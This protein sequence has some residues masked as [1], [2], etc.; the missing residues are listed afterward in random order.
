MA[1][2]LDPSCALKI[3]VK[4]CC[5]L[6]SS[7]GAAEGPARHL[8]LI[9]HSF[10]L[11]PFLFG[12][13]TAQTTP[14]LFSYTMEHLEGSEAYVLGAVGAATLIVL[15]LLLRSNPE[16][17]VPYN[18]TPPEQVKPGWK[19]E[20]LETP[21]LKVRPLEMVGEISIDGV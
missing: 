2:V 6:V 10:T 1:C 8:R 5:S 20:V 14:P 11:T 12:K 16:A 18:V 7:G 19:G 4:C 17:P 3:A 21:S 15:Y 13:F 9:G